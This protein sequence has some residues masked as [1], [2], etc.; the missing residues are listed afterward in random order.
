NTI[1]TRFEESERNNIFEAI[2]II[3]DKAVEQIPDSET[4]KKIPVV[5]PVDTEIMEHFVKPKEEVAEEEEKE[6]TPFKPIHVENMGN[7]KQIVNPF[8]DQQSNAP[9]PTE[10]R[11]TSLKD[12][13][14]IIKPVILPR[15]A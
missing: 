7:T 10:E 9:A 6:Q 3:L 5:K 2:N 15:G 12:M 14:P 8:S 4:P 11:V 13:T 1:E